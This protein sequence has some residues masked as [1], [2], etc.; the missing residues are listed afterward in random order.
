MNEED[1]IIE[2]FCKATEDML[3]HF[4][5]ESMA[6]TLEDFTDRTGCVWAILINMIEDYDLDLDVRSI[7]P[8]T[9]V[10]HIELAFPESDMRPFL[11]RRRPDKI[12]V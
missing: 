5:K 4:R 10:Y 7:L 3:R 12:D 11:L 1:K 8:V 6:H 9:H 2:S